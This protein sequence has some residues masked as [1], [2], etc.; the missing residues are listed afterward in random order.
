MDYFALDL[1]SKFQHLCATHSDIND[2]LPTLRR[3]ASQCRHVTE[4]GVRTAVST[5]ALLAAQPDRLV[6]YDLEL[7]RQFT[8]DLMRVKGR[9]NLTFVQGDTRTVEIEPC[10][11]LFIDTCHSFKQLSIELARHSGNVTRFLA[12]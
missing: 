9:T 7:N 1:E 3:Y 2:A 6:C 5:T 12:L 4:F 8:D 10:D 11:F